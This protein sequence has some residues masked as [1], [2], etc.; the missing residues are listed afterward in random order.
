MCTQSLV[1]MQ[2]LYPSNTSISFLLPHNFSMPFRLPW[3]LNTAPCHVCL[4]S[5]TS[6]PHVLPTLHLHMYF[7]HFTS[8]C[9]SYTSPPH[10]DVPPTLPLHRIPIPLHCPVSFLLTPPPTHSRPFLPSSSPPNHSLTALPPLLLTPHPLTHGP[11]SLPL[12]SPALTYVPIL[13]TPLAYCS[14][15]SEFT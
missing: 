2:S 11:S 3:P 8:T 7:L 10:G 6:P 13:M 5:Y 1:H 14:I 12:P 15:S 9:T 4:P